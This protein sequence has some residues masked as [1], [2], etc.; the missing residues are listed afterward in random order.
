MH[1][2]LTQK[3]WE[4]FPAQEKGDFYSILM[5]FKHID[6]F[7][8]KGIQNM[9]LPA[10]PG[11][12]RPLE[13]EIDAMLS[14]VLQSVAENAGSRDTSIYHGK[15][16][17]LKEALQL[18]RQ[19]QDLSLEPPETVIPY[20]Q[21]R[22]IILQNP[23]SLAV[24]ECPCR[25]VAEK[26]CLPPEE[27]EV[28]LFVGDPGASFIAQF[29]PK[30]RKT[31]QE[32]AARILEKCHEKGFVHCAYFKKDFARRFVAICNC[33][34]C[35]C[36]GMKAWNMFGE[37]V[38]ILAPSGYAAK[39]EDG[40]NGCGECVDSCGFGALRLDDETLR[41]V[42]DTA[43]CMGCGVCEDKCPTGDISMYREPSR[44]EPLDLAA[45]MQGV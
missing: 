21:A 15:V 1:H 11:P 19:K 32:E 16:M 20:K 25:A 41:G 26:S 42:V 40:C 36:L 17:Q 39:V 35:C 22:S 12:D 23:E 31:T 5:Y 10:G 45:L 3:L 14:Y 30:F 4:V 18:V 37:A 2:E 7:I 27:M 38:P 28:C 13:P 34:S 33:C 29:N 8:Y 6:H 9:G 43:K 24:G 44:G